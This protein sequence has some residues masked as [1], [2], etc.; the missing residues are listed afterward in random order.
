MPEGAAM[1]LYER[2]RSEAQNILKVESVDSCGL[3]DLRRIAST[4]EATVTVTPL[5]PGLSGFILKEE[6]SNP[7]IYINSLD[8]EQRQRFTLAHEIGHLIDRNV[9]AKDPEYSFLD[10]RGGECD[11]HEFFADEFAGEL[12]MPE[13]HI[14]WWDNQGKSDYEIARKFGV[15]MPTLQKR[16]ERLDHLAHVLELAGQAHETPQGWTHTEG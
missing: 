15:S 14:R 10:K 5:E 13:E 9:I 11:L 8:F 16:R 1:L 2:A 4:W 6:Y 12:L 7:R 3:D